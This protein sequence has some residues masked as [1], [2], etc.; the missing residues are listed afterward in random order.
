[1]AFHIGKIIRQRLEE[2]GMNKSEFARRINTTPQNIYGIFKRKSIDTDLLK[3]ISQVL[4]YDFFQYYSQVTFEVHEDGSPYS[5]EK[6]YEHKTVTELC[7]ELKVCQQEL[8]LLRKENAYL[9][10]IND[11]LRERAVKS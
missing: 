2:T 10:E 1:M 7:N 9:K 3:E 5:K 11:L 8:E 6:T 4:E